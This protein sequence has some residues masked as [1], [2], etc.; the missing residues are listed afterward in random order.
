MRR[1]GRRILPGVFAAGLFF[2]LWLPAEAAVGVV[3][4]GVIRVNCGGGAYTDKSGN[5]W[6]ADQEFQTGGWGYTGGIA[7]N[8][9]KGIDG[10]EDD[11]LYQS[12]RQAAPNLGY[13]FTV[14]GGNYQVVLKYAEAKYDS[15][16]R[17]VFSMVLEGLTYIPNLDLLAS[18]GRDKAFDRTFTITVSDG[19]LDVDFLNVVDF[20]QISAISVTPAEGNI[21]YVAV[22]GSDDNPGTIDRPWATVQKAADAL[23]AGDTVYLR[24]GRYYIDNEIIPRNS[25]KPERWITY[26]GYPG[27]TPIIDAVN[28][29]VR[30][31]SGRPPFDH[32]HGA[33]QIE[34]LCYIQIRD[35]RLENSHNA[36]FTVRNSHHIDFYNNTI[37]KTF[38]SCIAIWDGCRDHKVFGNTLIKGTTKE[39]E[40]RHQGY[41]PVGE[42][43]HEA[44]TIGGAANCEVAYNYLYN[45]DKEGIDFKGN[46]KNGK[47]HHNFLYK[48]ARTAIYVDG[49][50]SLLKDVEVFENV[51]E[52]CATGAMVSSEGG[53]LVDNVRIHH[54]L[55][56]YCRYAG[57]EINAWFG[58]DG[59]RSNIQ[60]YNN[61]IYKSGNTRGGIF[62]ETFN[63]KDVVIRNN[64]SADN[65][66]LQIGTAGQ[67]LKAFK[68]AIDYNLYYG[69]MNNWESQ[70]APMYPV[71]GS[72]AVNA[73]PMFNDPV[74][75][76]FYLRRGSP[77]I[78]AGHPDKEYRDPD[79]SRGDLG[80]FPY[81][82]VNRFWWKTNFP[83]VAGR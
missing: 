81:K 53:A 41:R 32:D 75:G 14:P 76:D 25:G 40:I 24:S 52:N 18:A 3:K 37:C 31:P 77:A 47:A 11:A 44:L 63:I 58:Q 8:A 20:A 9:K 72:K 36:G 65:W 6:A 79:G 17:R 55:F 38:S 42:A 80:A 7:V 10:T 16:N 78:N 49:W 64:I 70:G 57:V 43:P 46:C 60:I 34:G 56:Y 23:Q 27:E 1:S 69:K 83:P 35:I 71:P 73:D 54:N 30:P 66:I 39:M 61:T 4:E 48:L 29:F 59:P 51:A 45:C 82:A 15:V 62:L 28:H 33:F 22:D 12:S 50:G 21:Y 5:L 26:A 13:K 19:I 74:N 68:I 67:N 2:S